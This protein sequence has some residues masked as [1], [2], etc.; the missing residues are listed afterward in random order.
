MFV[1]M[2]SVFDRLTKV[3]RSELTAAFSR[4]G[5]DD[6]AVF[7]ETQ[8]PP[9]DG[10]RGPIAAKVTTRMPSIPDAKSAARVLDVAE[11]ATL[12]E[13]RAAY[14]RQAIAF[15]PRTLAGTPE[16]T[17]A[18]Q[19]IIDTLTEALEILEAHLLP[20]PPGPVSSSAPSSHEPEA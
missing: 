15:H 11:D 16:Q 2:T 7:D 18:A 1:G 17:L 3:V 8:P 9:T 20:L 13:V 4:E 12:D 19:T 14:R 5:D 6:D 10:E